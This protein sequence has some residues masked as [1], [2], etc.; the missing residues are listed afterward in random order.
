MF[1]SA[2]LRGQSGL[3]LA[4]L[5]VAPEFK[6]LG[7]VCTLATF[8]PASEQDDK[9]L[10]VPSEIDAVAWATIDLE[11]GCA[12]SDRLH[13]RG[14]AIRKP[15]QSHRHNRRCL[16]VQIVEPRAKRA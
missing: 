13:L 9:R 2:F 8:G 7:N 16:R 4:G 15:R 14:V 6:G 1:S 10:A 5:I 3:G 12:I 11:F